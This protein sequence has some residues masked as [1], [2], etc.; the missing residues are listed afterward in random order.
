M[1]STSDFEKGLVIEIEDQPWVIVDFQFVSPGKGAAFFRTKLKNLKTGKVVERTFK[2]GE[3]FE[4][5]EFEYKK[6]TYLYHDRQNAVFSLKENNQRVSLPLIN[7]EN[8]I[9]YLKQNSEIDLIYIDNELMDINLPKKVNLK[10]IEA[11]PATKG[12][13]ATNAYKTVKVETGLEVNV[14]LFI[15][16]GEIIRINTETGEYV[17]RVNE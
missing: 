6:A 7:V 12:N 15:K 17:E 8:K 1:V 14:P 3:R 11:A 4:E 5:M 13:T 16:E 2:S 10:I 9:R